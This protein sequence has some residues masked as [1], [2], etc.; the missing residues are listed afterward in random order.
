MAE[1]AIPSIGIA[2][3]EALLVKWL[4]EPGDHVTAG[5]AVAEIETDKAT[6]DLESPVAGRLGSHLAEPGAIVPVGTVV[7]EVVT[8]GDD[9]TPAPTEAGAPGPEPAESRTPPSAASASG[10]G[11]AESRKPH[12]RSPRARRLAVDHG[13]EAAPRVERFR[14]LIAEKVSQSWREIPH[15]AVT[16]EVDAEPMLQ[17]LTALRAVGNRAP[18]DAHRPAVARTGN[19]A[20]YTRGVERAATS[21]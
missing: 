7:V 17:T 5:E 18:T 1:I 9:A 15:F 19:G 3:T 12:T 14:E 11:A 20:R 8:A 16:R 2:M 21:D 6:M 13:V 4:K 10:P